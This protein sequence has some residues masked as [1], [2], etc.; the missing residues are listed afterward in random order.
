MKT[1]SKCL[2]VSTEI[3]DSSKCWSHLPLRLVF[4]KS[5]FTAFYRKIPANCPVPSGQESHMS[6]LLISSLAQRSQT[7]LTVGLWV[8]I[9][10]TQKNRLHKSTKMSMEMQ[11]HFQ[12]QKHQYV[13]M[14]LIVSEVWFRRFGEFISWSRHWSFPYAFSRMP[15]AEAQQP[16]FHCLKTE[17]KACKLSTSL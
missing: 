17:V 9:L 12:P 2:S 11:S 8:T 16:H 6:L 10:Y 3:L 13:C 15:H 14:L 4:L 7:W 5:I 1:A